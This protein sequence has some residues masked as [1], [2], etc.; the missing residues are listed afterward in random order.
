MSDEFTA[1]GAEWRRRCERFR[2]QVPDPFN[3]GRDVVDRLARDDPDRPALWWRGPDGSERRLSFG[4]VSRASDRLAAWLARR[5]VAPG[6]P[7]IVM[8]P[9][10]PEWHVAMVGALK[11]GALVIPSST[12]LRP[13]DLAYRGRHSAAVALIAGTEQVPVVEGV[14]SELDA[15]RH[16]L[17]VRADGESLPPGWEDWHQALGEGGDATPARET[18]AGVPAGG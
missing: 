15:L 12:I 5:G 11:A 3:F 8:L 14:R 6:A 18:R 13:K 1:A 10:V 17:V 9:K 16:R 4:E 2:W 7:V